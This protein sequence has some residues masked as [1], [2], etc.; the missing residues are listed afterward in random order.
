MQARL[1]EK[2]TVPAVWEAVH[3]PYKY[4]KDFNSITTVDSDLKV[5]RKLYSI[6]SSDTQFIFISLTGCHFHP[7][8][9][10]ASQCLGKTKFC[11]FL[12]SITG[13]EVALAYGRPLL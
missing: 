10:Y 8:C 7:R 3:H 6:P 11:C 4:E 5:K 12:S 9:Q 13:R 1:S 2:A